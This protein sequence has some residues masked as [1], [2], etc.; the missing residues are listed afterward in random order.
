[1]HYDCKCYVSTCKASLRGRRDLYQVIAG[2]EL[3]SFS[4]GAQRLSHLST[5][6]FMKHLL[7]IEDFQK[8][9]SEILSVRMRAILDCI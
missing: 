4:A 9:G 2:F 8:P 7:K 3:H 1:M 6:F 5:V